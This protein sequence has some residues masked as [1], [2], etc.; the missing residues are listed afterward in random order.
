MPFLVVFL[1]FLLTLAFAETTYLDDSNPAWRFDEGWRPVKDEP[2]TRCWNRPNV[3]G[4][5]NKTYHGATEPPELLG[6]GTLS[7]K[8]LTVS[9]FLNVVDRS[10]S[11]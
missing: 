7:F 2:C 5:F 4:A 9:A 3:N 8:G 11:F 1:S 10:T 6:A